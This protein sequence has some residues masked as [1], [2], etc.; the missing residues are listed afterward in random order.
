MEFRINTCMLIILLLIVLGVLLATGI[1]PLSVVLGRVAP[2]VSDVRIGWIIEQLSSDWVQVK[3]INM[4]LV[5]TGSETH[6]VVLDNSPDEHLVMAKLDKPGIYNITFSF[7]SAP[8]P[9]YLGY[10]KIRILEGKYYESASLDGTIDLLKLISKYGFIQEYSIVSG[11]KPITTLSFKVEIVDI[12][13]HAGIDGYYT[14][15]KD[16][17]VI[18]ES[19]IP[20]GGKQFNLILGES[21][22]KLV[23]YKPEWLTGYDS[24]SVSVTITK[25]SVTVKYDDEHVFKYGIQEIAG[26]TITIYMY[27]PP[28]NPPKTDIY[29]NNTHVSPEALITM[30]PGAMSL[31]I[32]VNDNAYVYKI[33]YTIYR[34][35]TVYD[36][37]TESIYRLSQIDKP[38]TAE[39]TTKKLESGRYTLRVTVDS[40]VDTT[41][42]LKLNVIV[43]PELT[44]P[45]LLQ[46]EELNITDPETN[47]TYKI[48]VQPTINIYILAIVIIIALVALYYYRKKTM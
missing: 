3:S 27:K 8:A 39:F 29:I 23:V 46:P 41:Y 13:T 20:V 21:T 47:T 34:D 19:T 12:T 33:S 5:F 26:K 36:T 38:V 44:Q 7:K 40:I 17:T 22:Y 10:P 43:E 30:N 2:E 42:D 24:E 6:I 15:Y 11:Y 16:D 37:G 9:A 25:D 31:K 32:V 4:S 45:I 28:E 1:I 48:T 35:K 14:L 18:D